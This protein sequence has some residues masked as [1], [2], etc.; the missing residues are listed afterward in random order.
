MNAAFSDL[1][2]LRQ[3]LTQTEKY[4]SEIRQRI[5][6]RMGDCSKALFDEGQISF[7]R[8]KDSEVFDADKLKT[9][10]PAVYSQFL[11]TREGSRRFVIQGK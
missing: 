10:Q 7:K 8:S 1:L 4:E 9:L 6:Q 3:H 11:K 2:S 5:Q